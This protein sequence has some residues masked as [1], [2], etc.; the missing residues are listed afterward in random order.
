[1]HTFSRPLLGGDGERFR[2]RLLG[3]VDV[4][5][6]ADQ[7]GGAAAGLTAKDLG[8]VRHA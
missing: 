6:D 4:A 1:V 2:H 8:E 5:E 7:G 3:E